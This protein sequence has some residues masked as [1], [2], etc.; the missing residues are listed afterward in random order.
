MLVISKKTQNNKNYITYK[1]LTVN[2]NNQNRYLL[3]IS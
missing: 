2:I 3:S 1:K